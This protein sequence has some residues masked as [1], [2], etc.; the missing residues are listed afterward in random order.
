MK[1]KLKQKWFIRDI[2]YDSYGRVFIGRLYR[3]GI[4]DMPADMYD[5]LPRNKDGSL[6]AWIEIMDGAPEEKV[7]K[8]PTTL[9]ELAKKAHE[10]D[11]VRKKLE[12]AEENYKNRGKK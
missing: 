3:K 1:V 9:S 2:P 10:D 4:H 8:Q 12:E 7:E 5:K 11:P 6:V